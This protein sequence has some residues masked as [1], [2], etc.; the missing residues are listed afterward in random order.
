VGSTKRVEVSCQRS[1][2]PTAP[3]ALAN[4]KDLIGPKKTTSIDQRLKMSEELNIPPLKAGE[5]GTDL[6][7]VWL[8]NNKLRVVIT[9]NLWNDPAPWGLLLADMVRHLANAYKERGFDRDEIVRRIK[10]VLDVEWDAPTSEV[11]KL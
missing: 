11:K 8:V 7:R 2:W 5:K 9:P 1:D 4:R 10:N 6:L 3:L